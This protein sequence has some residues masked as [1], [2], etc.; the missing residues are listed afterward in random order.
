MGFKISDLWSWHGTTGRG[1]YFITG[2]LLFSCKHLLD[3]LVATKVFGLRWSLFNYWV[4]GEAT[5]IDEM[6][7]GRL[8]F[9]G[10]LV[11]LAIPFIWVG[12]VLTL[13]RL[14]DAGLPHWLVAV[15]FLPFIN[16]LFF[17]LLSILP[18]R[19]TKEATPRTFYGR[20]RHALD[21]TIPEGA[22]G[23]AALGVLLTVLLSTGITVLSVQGLGNYG[24][25]LFVGLP[26]CLG[27]CSVLIYGYQH[28]RTLGSCIL[29]SLLSVA[30]ASLALIAVALE[31]VIC[32]IMAA[33]L[34]AVL[35]IFGGM[36]GYV[37][38]RRDQSH[39]NTS[40]THTVHAVSVILL[41]LPALM[42]IEHNAR[43]SPP[44]REVRTT[45]IINATPEQVWPRLV[46]FNELP[47]P[48]E[49]LF[50]TGIAYPLRA[51]IS[52]SGVGAVRHCVFSTGAFVEPIEVWDEPRL[53]KFG[54]TAQPPVMDEMS[55]YTN[56][57]PPH[58]N[59][60]LHSRKGQFL[61]TRL[62]DGRTQLEGTTWYENSF[63]PGLYWNRWSDY[64]IHRI[65]Q[66]VLEHIKQTSEQQ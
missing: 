29:V 24:W 51:E 53:L 4:F 36:I 50:R 11:A 30:L 20:V 38:Q 1:E 12:V 35:A 9:Y 3:R 63:W 54:V 10:T 46:A 16:L 55:P 52:G 5:K 32:I 57:K 43:L 26:F 21:R 13:R 33:P 7:Y 2:V 44:L 17:L 28:E 22:F 66:R 27:L 37:I 8:K 42:L 62:P 25:G 15:F 65:H 61:L 56:I 48:T 23:S 60:Y 58:L 39:Y 18:S 31:G 41:A 34:G 45:V 14:R 19:E 6:P 64:I 59:N 47:P 49:R 40:K